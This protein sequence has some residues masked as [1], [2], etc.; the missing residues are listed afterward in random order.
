MTEDIDVWRHERDVLSFSGTKIKAARLGFSYFRA[1][2]AHSLQFLGGGDK[3]RGLECLA[4]EVLVI[5]FSNIHM[6]TRHCLLLI[7]SP[8]STNEVVFGSRSEGSRAHV[9]VA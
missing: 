4:T 3:Y 2:V 7:W 5:Y 6:H 1:Y 9:F 8:Y